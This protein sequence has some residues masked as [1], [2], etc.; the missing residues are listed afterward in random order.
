MFLQKCR[1]HQLQ[2]VGAPHGVRIRFKFNLDQ[3]LQMMAIGKPVNMNDFLSSFEDKLGHL[4]IEERTVQMRAR[5]ISPVVLGELPNPPQLLDF[6]KRTLQV[7]LH[8]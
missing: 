2:E 8:V 7:G 5:S 1:T 6:A 3:R 4:D